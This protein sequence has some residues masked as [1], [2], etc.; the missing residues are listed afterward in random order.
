M[1]SSLMPRSYLL[2]C[3]CVMFSAL[4]TC[5]WGIPFSLRAA[6]SRSIY[7]TIPPFCSDISILQH[8]QCINKQLICCYSAN[9]ERN[10]HETNPET[11]L[12]QSPNDDQ[13]RKYFRGENEGPDHPV[14]VFWENVKENL[15]IVTQS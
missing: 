11:A 13:E 2:Y 12:V 9:M 1:G 14:T 7:S 8:K 5:R 4:H 6:D 10:I 3:C 15:D